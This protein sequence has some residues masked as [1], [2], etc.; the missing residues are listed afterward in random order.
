MRQRTIRLTSKSTAARSLRGGRS[1]DPQAGR[2]RT[3]AFHRLIACAAATFLLGTTACT[4]P[5]T[6][7]SPAQPV[8]LL[9]IDWVLDD[10]SLATL[11]H[12]VPAGIHIDLTFSGDQAS[13]SAGC[14][15]YGASFQAIG[16]SISFGPIRSTLRAC[17]HEVMAAEAAYLRALEGSTAYHATHSTLHLTGGPVDLTFT[18]ASPA[19]GTASPSQ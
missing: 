9:G 10:A 2:D 13:G 11:V 6:H 1:V 15:G 16:G 5:S 18:A 8:G 3:F 17:A 4:I 19:S 12:A 14:N 7:S